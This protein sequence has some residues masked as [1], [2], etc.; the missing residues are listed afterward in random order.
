M[1]CQAC[2]HENA[3]GAVY[4]GK[5][6]KRLRFGERYIVKELLGTGSFGAVYRCRDENLSRDVAI[7]QLL[8]QHHG[9]SRVSERFAQE[10]KLLAALEHPNIVKIFD[11]DAK[12]LFIVMEYVQA[13]DLLKTEQ[14]EPGY[15]V[16]NFGA[17]VDALTRALS[18]AHSHKILH[19]D[20]KFENILE[21]IS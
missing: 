7:K 20:L 10:A 2:G 13:K 19:R 6:S 4:C 21:A 11:Y 18:C 15:C 17:I 12:E 16:K 1:K 5:C 3:E 9:D 8:P 14:D